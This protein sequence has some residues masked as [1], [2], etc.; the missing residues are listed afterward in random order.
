LQ[1]YGVAIIDS[2]LERDMHIL[3]DEHNQRRVRGVV[4]SI[5]RNLVAV[6]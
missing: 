2:R 4:K 5:F 6:S 3:V 1:F